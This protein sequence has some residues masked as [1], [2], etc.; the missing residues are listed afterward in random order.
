MK[1]Y[2]KPQT[3]RECEIWDSG[4]RCGLTLGIV[5]NIFVTIAIAL[6]T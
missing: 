5:I 6:F 1:F 3:I 4:W 2:I